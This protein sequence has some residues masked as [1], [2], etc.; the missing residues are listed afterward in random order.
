MLYLGLCDNKVEKAAQDVILYLIA[1]QENH[2]QIWAY[3][4]EMLY[5]K[6]S[7]TAI[8]VLF[9]VYTYANMMRVTG[10]FYG[11]EASKK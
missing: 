1:V 6:H 5:N 9:P 4:L 3:L 11:T 7:V 10:K 8:D 2:F